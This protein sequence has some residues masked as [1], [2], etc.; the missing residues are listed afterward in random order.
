MFS[1][2]ALQYYNEV[3]ENC[4]LEGEIE[5]DET[6]LYK[7]KVSYAPAR[8][9]SYDDIWLIGFKERNSQRFLIFPTD[10]KGSSVFIPLLIVHVKLKSTIY[11]DG[12]SV[13]VN[14]RKFPHESKLQEFGFVHHFNEHK[15]SFV[16]E[17]FKE[18]HT[19]TIE[20][21]WRT[22]KTHIRKH[23][24]RKLYL[25]CIGRFFFQPFSPISRKEKIF[26]QKSTESK[27]FL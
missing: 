10:D 2:I 11:T 6:K 5:I 27:D 14:T 16:N 9:Y 12:F 20:R 21:L 25:L 18:I 7:K 23:Q 22:L 13:Y 26:S 15:I 3:H 19:N 24:T 4:L 1:C 8:P 17:L